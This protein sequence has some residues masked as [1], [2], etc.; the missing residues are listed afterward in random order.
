M[1][2]ARPQS[3]Y[4]MERLWYV[5]FISYYPVLRCLYLYTWPKLRYIHFSESNFAILAMRKIDVLLTQVHVT[6]F[7]AVIKEQ[8]SLYEVVIP[9]IN[10]NEKNV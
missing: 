3:F 4:K 7:K 1:S 8:E 2:T 5:I 9:L 6:I 10:V